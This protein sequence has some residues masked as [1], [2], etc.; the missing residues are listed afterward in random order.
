[1][2]LSSLLLATVTTLESPAYEPVWIG[3]EDVMVV[4]L[5]D[6]DL[7]PAEDPAS[8]DRKKVRRL[9]LKSVNKITTD[10]ATDTCSYRICYLGLKAGEY[11]LR[12][13]LKFSPTK[14]RHM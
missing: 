12:D 7:K 8:V 10:E 1:M 3:T 14:N 9:I 2:L 11:D 4:R 13:Y 6:P 5:N